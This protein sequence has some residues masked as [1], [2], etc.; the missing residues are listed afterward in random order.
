MN[1]FY[2]Y[3]YLR[4][5]NTPYYIGKGKGYRAWKSKGRIVHPP[6]D[7]N[8]LV[9]YKDN[10][11]ED[12]AFELEKQ[13]IGKYGRKDRGT[14]I[15]SN[16]TDGGGGMSH[17]DPIPKFDSIMNMEKNTFNCIACGRENPIKGASY[18]S[19]YCNNKCQS[20]HRKK[21]LVEKRIQEWQADC[22]L[23]NWK[24]VP[25]Y[26]KDYLIQKRGAHCETC[27][28]T[29]HAGKLIPLVV[30]QK[31]KNTHNNVETNLELICLNC[32][33]QK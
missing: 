5:D 29:E 20:D 4:E 33:A 28:C 32:R 19:K 14:G 30:N 2:V 12:E 10:L 3:G 13:L 9:I 31:D 15:L 25:E 23:Y 8:K 6:K 11:T 1:E 22:S 24:E 26:I 27:S 17:I 16:K 21:L 18:L 7:K